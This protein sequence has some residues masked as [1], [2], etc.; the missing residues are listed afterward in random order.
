MEDL[1]NVDGCKNATATGSLDA[2]ATAA[3]TKALFFCFFLMIF[4]VVIKYVG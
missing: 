2:M 3:T 4:C 1:W